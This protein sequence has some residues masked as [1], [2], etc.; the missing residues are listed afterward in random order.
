MKLEPEDRRRRQTARG[1][2]RDHLAEHRWQRIALEPLL[3]SRREC[4]D[5]DDRGE[6]ELEARVEEHAGVPG[7]QCQRAEQEEVPPVGRPGRQPGERAERSCNSRSHDRGLRPDGEHVAADRGERAQLAQPA[8]D[9]QQ[10]RQHQRAGGD[11]RHVLPG[12]SEQVVEPGRSEVLAQP[13]AEALL[14]TEDNSQE[15]SAALAVQ[16]ACDGAAEP[17]VQTVAQPAQSVAM[18]HHSPAVAG[19]HDMDAVTPEP[20]SLIEAVAAAARK[21]RLRAHLEHGAPRWCSAERKLELRGLVEREQPEAPDA[22]GHLQVEA[23]SSRRCGHD[24]QRATEDGGGGRVQREAE[25][26]EAAGEESGSCKLDRRVHE[27][28]PARAAPEP[29]RARSREAAPGRA[30]DKS[31]GRRSPRSPAPH[32]PQSP[33]RDSWCAPRPR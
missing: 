13:L 32:S 29:G 20:G 11:Q 24:D 12:H 5:R 18:S 6:R 15:D 22:N 23:A 30:G 9:A 14:V 28:D 21:L 8:W 26:K 3:E 31:P 10:P 1:R 2:D 7:Q 17:V 33:P 27:A 25:S 4:E 19:Q 16:P